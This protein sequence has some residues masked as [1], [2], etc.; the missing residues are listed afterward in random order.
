[1]RQNLTL[2]GLLLMAG[3]LQLAA[4]PDKPSFILKDSGFPASSQH[5]IYW[6]DNE[7]VIFTGYEIDLEKID[8]QGKYGREQNIYIWDTRENHRS[9]Y[10][11]NASLG[12]YSAATFA[13]PSLTAHQ[14]KG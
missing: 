2:I 4:A 14:R 7:R 8:K 13:T 1:M 5:R 11:K 9:I 6:L 3:V 10:V 12:C